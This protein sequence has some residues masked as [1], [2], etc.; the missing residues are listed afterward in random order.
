MLCIKH[1]I[2][3]DVIKNKCKAKRLYKN[4]KLCTSNISMIMASYLHNNDNNII[5]TILF[6]RQ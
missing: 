5:K 6:K 4:F 1:H 2:K 3:T